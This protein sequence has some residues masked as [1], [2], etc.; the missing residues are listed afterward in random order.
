LLNGLPELPQF[1]NEA[2][3]LCFDHK[4]KSGTVTPFT[5]EGRLSEAVSARTI[6]SVKYEVV[7]RRFTLLANDEHVA[8]LQ[9]SVAEWNA[10]R[11]RE[12]YRPK[13]EIRIDLS[14]ADFREAKLES[15]NLCFANLAGINLAGAGLHKAHLFE[16]VLDDAC[17]RGADFTWVNA[18][19]AR[20]HRADLGWARLTGANFTRAD[21][22]HTRI[23]E[24]AFIDTNLKEAIGLEHCRHLWP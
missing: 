23:E 1:T 16:A 8:I 19:G 14:G 20:L 6:A 21:F 5:Q 22:S 17:L 7:F 12:M 2:L 13:R 18:G 10:W 4:S 24:T 9:R 3:N 11:N 15:A